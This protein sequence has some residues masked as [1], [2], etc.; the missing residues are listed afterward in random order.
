[1]AIKH[2]ALYRFFSTHT[3]SGISWVSMCTMSQGTWVLLRTRRRR[4]EKASALPG[5]RLEP[6]RGFMLRLRKSKWGMLD[7]ILL[8]Y[9]GKHIDNNKLTKTAFRLVCTLITDVCDSWVVL[10]LLSLLLP[11][12]GVICTFNSFSCCSGQC[13]CKWNLFYALLKT[14]IHSYPICFIP[15]A[16]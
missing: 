4:P 10:L 11:C 15:F 12:L 1:M 3:Y 9:R 6:F 2:K 13:Y 7:R 16:Y 14:Y 5:S 8:I